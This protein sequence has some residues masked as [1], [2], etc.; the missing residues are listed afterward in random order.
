MDPS[1]RKRVNAMFV[2]R[3]TNSIGKT[4]LVVAGT[5]HKY[6]GVN[7]EKIRDELY[8]HIFHHDQPETLYEIRGIKIKFIK[9]K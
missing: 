6:I 7:G 4:Q 1:L 8:G 2:I 9:R 5:L 3:F